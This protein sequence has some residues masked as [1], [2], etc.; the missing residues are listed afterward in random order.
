[1]LGHQLK[2]PTA[3]SMSTVAVLLAGGARAWLSAFCLALCAFV[4]A[5]IVQEFVR[6]ANVRR[7]STRTDWLTALV[8]LVARNRRRYGGYI[9]HLGIV[10]I[11]VGFAGQGFKQERQVLLE[12]G[13]RATLGHYAFRYD[14]LRIHDDGQK[15]MM[16]GSLTL[17][18][19]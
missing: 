3:A 17:F 1:R 5:T 16:S 12:P 14:S 9:V 11:M 7:A 4:A 6:G 15:Q 2:W 8:G 19:D 10:L 13:Q 18:E